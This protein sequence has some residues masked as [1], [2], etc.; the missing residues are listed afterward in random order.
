MKKVAVIGAGPGGLAAAKACLEEGLTPVVFEKNAEVGGLWRGGT[1]DPAWNGMHTNLSKW[2]CAFSDFPWPDEAQDFPVQSEVAEYLKNFTDHFGLRDN[3]RFSTRVARISC[4]N[5]RWVVFSGGSGKKLT[6]ENFDGVIVASGFF[7]RETHPVIMGLDGA[8]PENISH[9]RTFDP[10]QI[11]R[12]QKAAVVG[13]SFSGYEI[14]AEFAA[15]CRRPP[16]HLIRNNPAWVIKRHFPDGNGGTI[17]NDIVF[18]SRE[19]A[20]QAKT[21]KVA[22]ARKMRMEFFES[23]FGNPGDIDFNLRPSSDPRNPMFIA[24]SDTYL[25]LADKRKIEVVRSLEKT[26]RVFD[27]VVLATGFHSDLSYLCPDIRGEIGYEP[28]DQLMP[29]VLHEATWP[30]KSERIGFVGFYRG[31]YFATMEMQARWVAG[32]FAGRLPAPSREERRSGVV[33]ALNIKM[34]LPR[35]QFPYADY[36]GLTDRLAKYAGCYPDLSPSDPLY[37][38]VRQG[39]FLPVHFRLAGPGANRSYVEDQLAR[40]PYVPKGMA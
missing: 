27:R 25:D 31:P 15:A 20:A 8:K 7:S 34:Q 12:W 13:G 33:D 23:A 16:V 10:R 22:D 1:D 36:V 18:Y 29:V 17:P 6:K 30:R 3:I 32:V 28:D 39:P 37:N 19:K 40:N 38:A 35:P 11:E 2:T 5:D 24:I 26:R 4:N 14:A 21:M 9:S